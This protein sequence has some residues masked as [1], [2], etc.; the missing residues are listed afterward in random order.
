M[1]GVPLL[2]AAGLLLGEHLLEPGRELRADGRVLREVLERVFQLAPVIAQLVCGQL[3]VGWG[4]LGGGCMSGPGPY[5]IGCVIAL[6]VR[7]AFGGGWGSP[8]KRRTLGMSPQVTSNLYLY[9]SKRID[10]SPIVS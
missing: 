1:A 3:T 8:V 2:P 7:C 4:G 10:T 6:P 9:V 5:G